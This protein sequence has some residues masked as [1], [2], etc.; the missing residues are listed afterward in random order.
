MKCRWRP[1]RDLA[2]VNERAREIV[3]GV[4]RL[5]SPYLDETGLA[6]LARWAG[7]A[8]E[9]GEGSDICEWFGCDAYVRNGEPN[10]VALKADTYRSPFSVVI[11]L[12][13]SKRLSAFRG[14]LPDAWDDPDEWRL[15]DV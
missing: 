2:T 14:R 8:S 13:P 10:S 1:R 7:P 11:E 5:V 15:R 9:I 3:D 6:I 4:V 12:L